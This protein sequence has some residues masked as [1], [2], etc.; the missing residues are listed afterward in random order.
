VTAIERTERIHVG[1]SP[2]Q[3]LSIRQDIEP[4]RHAPIFALVHDL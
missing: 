4:A 3:Q 1:I 2:R